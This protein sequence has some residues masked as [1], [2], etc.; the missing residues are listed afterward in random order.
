MQETILTALLW[1]Y[2]TFDY[3]SRLVKTLGQKPS[4]GLEILVIKRILIPYNRCLTLNIV[5][6]SE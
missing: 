3:D 4:N 6:A 5:S 1:L 2:L